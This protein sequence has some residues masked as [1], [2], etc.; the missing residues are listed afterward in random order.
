MTTVTLKDKCFHLRADVKEIAA[1]LLELKKD[2]EFTPTA[3]N[4]AAVMTERARVLAPVG[5][6]RSKEPTPDYAEMQENLMLAYR[7]LEDAGMR[8]GKLVQALDG[9]T[10]VYPR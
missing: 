7:A 4:L 10:S 6:D 9:G 2:N 5:E 1:N 3:Q 8:I